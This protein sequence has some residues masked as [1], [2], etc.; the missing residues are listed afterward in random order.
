MH[1]MKIFRD[2]HAKTSKNFFTVVL[3]F[4]LAATTL[5]ACTTTTPSSSANPSGSTNPTLQNG[6]IH[7]IRHIVVIMQENRSFDSYFGTFPGA[8]GIPM[9]NDGAALLDGFRVCGRKGADDVGRDGFVMDGRWLWDSR[10]NLR[11]KLY[12]NW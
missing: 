11:L 9:L 6:D 1:L 12:D 10:R 5:A 3:A 4:L 2:N 8:D 7:K